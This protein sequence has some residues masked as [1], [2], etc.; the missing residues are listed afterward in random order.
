MYP[1]DINRIACIGAGF[2]GGPLGAVIAS[3]CSS[4]QVTVVDKDPARIHAWNSESLPLHELQLAEII[5]DIREHAEKSTECVKSRLIFST[6][7]QTAVQ[8]AQ[9]I[10]LCID[11]PTR[12]SGP[13]S[14]FAPDLGNLKRAIEAIARTATDDKILVAKSTVPSGTS[15]VIRMLFEQHCR[16]DVK[17]EV[18]SNPEF[19]SEGT[20]IHD[21]LYP[22][23][24][25]IGSQ[26]T[27]SGKDAA[28]KLAG[29]YQAW[30]PPSRIIFTDSLSAELGKLAANAMLAQRVSN[31]NTLGT[32]CEATGARIE[33]V[34]QICGLDPRIGPHML[35][36]SLGWGGG[37]FQKDILS[38]VNATRKLGLDQIASY[39]ESV[40]WMNEHHKLNFQ[41]RL[42]SCMGGS[43]KG[44]SIT[45][46]GFAFKKGTSDTKNSPA[47]S[48]I[49]GLL[50]CQAQVIIYDP[51]VPAKQIITDLHLTPGELERTTISH[52]PYSACSGANAVVVATDWDNFL[53]E[54][55]RNDEAQPLNWEHIL[56]VMQEP[57]FIFDG[58]NILDCDFIRKL[59][60]RYVRV[61][62]PSEW[63]QLP[64]ASL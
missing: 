61:G 6:D 35:K 30:V 20:A 15:Q 50:A 56:K 3:K 57:K 23:R 27:V 51:M 55:S 49:R 11:T 43:I 58:R 16:P 40:V 48:L 52:S 18:L 9:L 24:V 13:G 14:G 5:S 31:I 32:I 46:L 21:L 4:V 29:V 33:S 47:I 37:C 22:N 54:L 12:T 53:C 42:V 26:Q 62:S 63:D 28:R 2:V 44:R 10:F 25:V 8:K 17:C 45:V 1:L 64:V 36:A 60:G 7:I 59:G 34:S 41:K 19:L 38:L 39:W